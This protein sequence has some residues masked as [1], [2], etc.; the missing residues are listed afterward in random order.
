MLKIVYRIIILIGVFIASLYYFSRDIKE[1]VFDTQKTIEMEDASFP[2]MTLYTGGEE[3]NQLYGYST[4]L[5]ATVVRNSLVPIRED[6]SF[7]I[8]IDQKKYEV[9]KLNYEVRKFVGNELVES[10]S[11]SVF[12]QMED[13]RIKGRIKIKTTLDAN[14]EYAMKVVLVTSESKKMHYYFR[15]SRNNMNYLNDQLDFVRNFNESIQ[16]KDKAESMIDYLEPKRNSD[17][18]TLSHVNINSSFDLVSWGNI[19]PVVTYTY[20]PVIYE[21]LG[22]IAILGLDFI[23]ESQVTGGTE[24]YQVKEIYRVR[25]TKDRMY[26]LNYD[27]YM[28]SIFDVSNASVSQSQLKLGITADEEVPFL[29]KD[30]E[31]FAFVR[32]REL[33]FYDLVSNEM[34][35]VFSFAQSEELDIREIN[36]QHEVKILEMDAE[37]NL[38]FMVYGYMNRGQYEGRVGVIL[39]RYYRGEDRIEELVYVPMEEPYEVIQQNFGQFGYMN[40][41]NVFYFYVYESIFAYNLITKEVKTIA[42]HV[43][44][45]QLVYLDQIQYLAWQSTDGTKIEN[46]INLINLET[47]AVEELSSKDGYHIRLLDKIDSNIIYGFVKESDIIA[48][49][50]GSQLIPFSVIEITSVEQQVLK[51]Y[52]KANH[53]VTEIKVKENVVE[54][55]RVKRGEEAGISYVAAT[56]DY[57]MNQDKMEKP[58]IQVTSR[59]TEDTL[60]EWYLAL[61]PGFTMTNVPKVKE[62]INTIIS[63]DPTVRVPSERLV[64]NKYY[65]YA[66]GIMM[67]AFDQASDAIAVANEAVGVVWSNL[68]Y[69]IWER[70]VKSTKNT[71]S[72]IENMDISYHS[73]ESLVVAIDILLSHQGISGKG[74]DISLVKN[75]AMDVLENLSPNPPINL[76][77]ATL[78]EV[79]YYVSKEIPVIGIVNEDEALL[80][81]G[82]DNFNLLLINPKTKSKVRMG[83]KSANSMFEASGNVFISYLV[84]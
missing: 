9:K 16:D 11:M 76:S 3:I 28:E 19:K 72:K 33:W 57:I 27:R 30:K 26:L 62:T 12:D 63:V 73:S 55:T 69:T 1:V 13:G 44:A 80:I 21:M 81:Y 34:T 71:I 6:Q 43:A 4:N 48:K 54:L 29:S 20:P 84:E 70:G 23:V 40:H 8:L 82:Y 47:G 65:A 50:D 32:N 35:K 59:V 36:D 2:L 77:G 78:D 60:T 31:K 7:E 45:D 49:M 39:Y 37:G 42:S 46:K 53:F 68:G 79:L 17:N 83:I 51:S 38:D 22:D 15:V 58:L 18:S 5:D 64:Q 41:S 14:Q 74:N 75:S 52:N 61:P 25:Y 56:Q 67:G 10:D 24:T 66:Q